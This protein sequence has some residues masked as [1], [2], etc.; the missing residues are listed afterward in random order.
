MLCIFPLTS[1]LF[2]CIFL[3]FLFSIFPGSHQFS[4]HSLPFPLGTFQLFGGFYCHPDASD[5]HI[6]VFY[7]DL[8]AQLSP[9]EP[10]AKWMPLFGHHTGR[11]YHPVSD[12]QIKWRNLFLS[13]AQTWWMTLSV[14]QVWNQE[15]I[16]NTFFL[17]ASYLPGNPALPLPPLDF[18][19]ILLTTGLWYL[20]L[21]SYQ[22]PTG[23]YF[24]F[25][26]P[27]MSPT[28]WQKNRLLQMQKLTMPPL[29]WKLSTVWQYPQDKVPVP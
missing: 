22:I 6:H 1:Y 4:P 21:H 11:F 9:K 27:P 24:S 12:M 2:C 7:P 23:S 18:S 8:T 25:Y 10:T 20:S 13:Y 26:P 29:R 5:S 14:A 19:H 16:L 28:Q 3:K 17:R 15:I